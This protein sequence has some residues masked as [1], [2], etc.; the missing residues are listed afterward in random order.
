MGFGWDVVSRERDSESIYLQVENE[1]IN[2]YGKGDVRELAHQLLGTPG[3]ECARIVV[4]TF[5]LNISPEE[6]LSE[7]DEA[8]LSR[9]EN[10][11][12]CPDQRDTGALSWLK[13]LHE[14]GF[15][16]TIA[17]SSCRRLAEK[18]LTIHWSF[19]QPYLNSMVCREDVIYGKPCPDLFLLAAKKMNISVN[20]CIVL[21]DAPNGVIA[22]K[23][24]GM[25][26]VAIRN[27]YLS[28]AY[29]KEADWIVDTLE[30][31]QP[32]TINNLFS[33]L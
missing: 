6:Y 16:Q 15:L 1:I 31:W 4:D 18:K 14:I 9:F 27:C 7:R 25:K 26:C 3:L 13:R 23:R 2:K 32:T 28:K 21:E 33:S 29:Y 5:Q 22:A 17:T 8:L 30:Q 11:S 10:V 12:F 24:A 20:H 19:L